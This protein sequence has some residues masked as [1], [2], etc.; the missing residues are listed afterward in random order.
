MLNHVGCAC[1]NKKRFSSILWALAIF[2][3]LPASLIAVRAQEASASGGTTASR[4]FLDPAGPIAASQLSHFGTISLIMIFMVIVPIFIAIPIILL[5]YR[6]GARGTYKPEWEFNWGVE[7]FIWALPII[8]VIALATALWKDTHKYDPYAPLGENPLQIQV[9]SLD[10]KFL[11]LYP[12]QGIATVNFLALPE[13]RPVTL[14]LTSATVMQSFMV[15]R[16]AGQIYT[17]AGMTTELNL[18]ADKPG[19][20]TGRNMQYNGTGFASQSF[21]TEVMTK[22]AFTAWVANTRT[23]SRQ[24]NWGEYENL[25]KPSLVEKPVLYSSFDPNFF[26]KIISRFAPERHTVPAKTN[27][28]NGHQEAEASQ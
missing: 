12:E 20:Y 24:L 6:R 18:V 4:G 11:F 16:L 14:T 27:T 17:M 10:W 1:L 28:Q 21:P 23:A 13:K 5:R 25:L 15:P 9:V 26:N 2:L 3:I 19:T 8:I 22:D 7:L